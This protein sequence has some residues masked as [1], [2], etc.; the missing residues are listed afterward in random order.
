MRCEVRCPERNAV[1][2]HYHIGK[3]RRAIWL[4]AQHFH[5][6]LVKRM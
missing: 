3:D 4:F 1:V 2:A 5:K 6:P